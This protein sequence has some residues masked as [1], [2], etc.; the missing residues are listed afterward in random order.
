VLPGST[1]S[2]RIAARVVVV[3]AR[4]SAQEVAGVRVA[5]SKLASDDLGANPEPETDDD[6]A[7]AAQVARPALGRADE[8]AP[9]VVAGVAGESTAIE[10]TLAADYGTDLAAL[11]ERIRQRV[12]ERVRAVTGLEPAVVTVHIDDVFD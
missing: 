8:H 11:G 1:G 12:R 7:S 10:I 3:T 4:R 2:T 6:P 9:R 5:L